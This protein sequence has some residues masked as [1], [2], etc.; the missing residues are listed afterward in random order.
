[1]PRVLVVEDEPLRCLELGAADFLTKPFAI[2]E[3]L[4]RVHARLRVP[5]AGGD[6]GHR[7]TLRAFLLAALVRRA[8]EV[9]SRQVLLSEVWGY[10]FDPGTNVIDV[11]VGRLRSKLGAELIETV[12]HAGYRLD[13]S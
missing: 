11:Y 7:T 4:A 8:G 13:P 9:A 10:S 1:M 2:A 3:L 12:R 6:G 5:A